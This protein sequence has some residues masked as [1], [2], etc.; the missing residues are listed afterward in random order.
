MKTFLRSFYFPQETRFSEPLC[1][2][3]FLNLST[4]SAALTLIEI[5]RIAG[6][7]SWE[8]W[9]VYQMRNVGGNTGNAVEEIRIYTY[10]AKE[11]LGS[12]ELVPRPPF[13]FLTDM[14]IIAGRSGQEPWGGWGCCL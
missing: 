4:I 9:L 6:E 1:F 5:R 14:I 2:F 10:C 3:S 13:R 11:V 8:S 7:E 12:W